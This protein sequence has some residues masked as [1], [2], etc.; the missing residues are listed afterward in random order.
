MENNHPEA[1]LVH[2][3]NGKVSTQDVCIDA[4]PCFYINHPHW[5]VFLDELMFYGETE[6]KLE[7]SLWVALTSTE[8][9]VVTR[10]MSIFKYS[11]ED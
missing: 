7:R 8:H 4:A 1:P 2:V 10:A 9:I 6:I 3:A 11:I 5:L